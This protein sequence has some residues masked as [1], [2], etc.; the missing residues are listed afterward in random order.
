[1]NFEIFFTRKVHKIVIGIHL[2]RELVKCFQ[3]RDVSTKGRCSLRVLVLVRG[4]YIF[5][6]RGL[7]L[8]AYLPLPRSAG[9]RLGYYYASNLVSNVNF[10]VTIFQYLMDP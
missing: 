4:P 1:M 10:A 5:L 6:A 9:Y 3:R 7:K 8:C 2:L